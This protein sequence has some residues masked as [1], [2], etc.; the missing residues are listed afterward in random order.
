VL[1]LL[2]YALLERRSVEVGLDT[3]YYHKMTARELLRAFEIVDLIELHV[4]GQPP[5]WELRLSAENQRLL[6][7]L[8]FPDPA[9]YLHLP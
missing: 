6:T 9:T 8:G 7:R 1:A 3:R 5:H 2:I 4:R